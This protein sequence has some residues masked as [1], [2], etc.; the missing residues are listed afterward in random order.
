MPVTWGF[1]G[2]VLTL[3]VIGVVTNQ[4]I[5]R[6]FDEAVANAPRRSDL[7][8]LWDAR[9]SQTPVSADDM[10]WRFRLVAALAARGILSRAALL[11]LSEHLSLLDIARRQL[12][13]ALPAIQSEVFTE[14]AKALAWLEG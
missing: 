7:R 2:H 9:A 3:S 6:A 11:V 4:E 5:E 13:N 14:S 1:R 8:L 12:Q 10:D